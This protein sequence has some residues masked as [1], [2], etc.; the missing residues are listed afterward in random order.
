MVRI[1]VY[2]SLS[3]GP[4][5]APDGPDPELLAAGT[6]MR[7]AI[8]DD[9]LRLDGGAGT[10]AVAGAPGGAARHRRAANLATAA[11]R[12]GEDAETFVGRMAAVHDL[13]WIVAPETG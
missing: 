8:V 4:P 9:L 10:C 3:A 12:A 5:A 2:E 7:D 6:A 11:A 1:F 13:C